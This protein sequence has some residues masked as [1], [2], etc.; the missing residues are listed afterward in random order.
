MGLTFELCL[1]VHYTHKVGY[2][3]ILSSYMYIIVGY[4][5]QSDDFFLL[6][7]VIGIWS[8]NGLI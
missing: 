6:C 2:M 5:V 7:N 3:Y 8:D 4:L 1:L